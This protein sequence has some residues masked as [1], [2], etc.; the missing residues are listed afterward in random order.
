MIKSELAY[1]MGIIVLIFF[2]TIA[3][4]KKVKF[5]KI[6]FGCA[7]VIYLTVVA[8]ITLFPIYIDEKIVYTVGDNWYNFIPFYTISKTVKH[9]FDVTAFYQIIGNI[10]LAIPYG[11]S[12]MLLM[13]NKKWWKLLIFAPLF[14]VC[15]ELTQLFIGLGIDN[16][17][18]NV[19][20]DDA[21][22]NTLGALIGY[23]LYII[24][25]KKLLKPFQR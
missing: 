5:P 12:V 13:K 4:I 10:C 23:G 22:L 19:D 6:F 9:G 25:P 21:I 18:R 17:Y 3:I 11:F 7:F 15:V 16:M 1:F 8:D 2:I 20:I 24:V 14:T